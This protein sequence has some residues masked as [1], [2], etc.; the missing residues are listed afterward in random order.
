MSA[1]NNKRALWLIFVLILA[2]SCAVG[3]IDAG[4]DP[5]S[6]MKDNRAVGDEL[7]AIGI[8][9]CVPLY[10]GSSELQ[11][12][13]SFNIKNEG[14]E[15]ISYDHMLVSFDGGVNDIDRQLWFE[16]PETLTIGP[17]QTMPYEF[18]SGKDTEWLIRDSVQGR[19]GFHVMLTQDIDEKRSDLIFMQSAVL[20]TIIEE[21]G[22]KV[23]LEPGQTAR[24]YFSS[25]NSEVLEKTSSPEYYS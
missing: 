2:C 4:R 1:T 9:E 20:P 18:L 21:K 12:R 6:G 7:T 11:Y 25:D 19:V 15:W 16:K 23:E 5:A 3:C 24:I 8:A 22:L 10:E 14:D 13:V 17:G